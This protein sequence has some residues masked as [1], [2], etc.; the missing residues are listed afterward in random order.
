MNNTTPFRFITAILTLCLC[1]LCVSRP[2]SA[3]SNPSSAK[4]ISI[5]SE[6]K[7][8]IAAYDT[9]YFY[10]Q[11]PTLYQSKKN[12]ICIALSGNTV[13]LQLSALDSNGASLSIKKGDGI[14]EI[15]DKLSTA[16]RCFLCIHNCLSKEQITSL[17]ISCTQTKTEFEKP[18]ATAD[19]VKKASRK[20]NTLSGKGAKKK[21]PVRKSSHPNKKKTDINK[22]YHSQSN[23]KHSYQNRTLVPTS[24]QPTFTRKP[25]KKKTSK[26]CKPPSVS[27]I[28]LPPPP[29]THFIRLRQ[30]T[31]LSLAEPLFDGIP[32]TH[33]TYTPSS[34][35][36]IVNNGI[37]Y[38]PNDGLFYLTIAYGNRH[39]TCT[40]LVTPKQ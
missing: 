39:T 7:I 28:A 27:P 20:T 17:T 11:I 31:S 2:L 16:D 19:R 5:G 12:K 6:K 21:S 24:N 25:T 36:V 3:K 35:S 9:E 15:S 14:Y 26:T 18:Q 10:F 30:G 37:I 1:I 29:K 22:S 13:G 32:E 8:T 40:I 33:I 38:V 4:N 23:R 34:S